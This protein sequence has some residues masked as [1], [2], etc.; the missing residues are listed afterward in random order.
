MNNEQS[1]YYNMKAVVQETGLN[2]M[3][4]RT[5]ERRY[6]LPRPQ[7]SAGGHRQYTQRDIDTFLWL[8]AR[9]AEGLSVRHAA[10]AWHRIEEQG[11]DPLA[12]Q[13]A[14]QGGPVPVLLRTVD[15]SQL[16]ELRDNPIT[17]CLA[18]NKEAAEEV[19]TRAFSCF[20]AGLVCL[21]LLQKGVAQIGV[22]WYDGEISIQQEHFA[23]ALAVRRLDTLVSATARPVRPG[24][25]LV[26]CAP[27]DHHVFSP[28]LLTFLLQRRGWDT[29][30][31]GANVPAQAL[32]ASIAQIR[33]TLVIISAQRLHAAVNL[34]DVAW[35]L[36]EQDVPMG[37]GGRIFNWESSLRQVIPGHFLGESLE[38][39]VQSVETLL[40]GAKGS[41]TPLPV[42]SGVGR[43]RGALQQF[44]ARRALIESHVVGAFIADNHPIDETDAHERGLRTHDHGGAQVGQCAATRTFQTL[45]GRCADQ[46]PP[47]TGNH[48]RLRPGIL[49]CRQNPFGRSGQS[50]HRLAGR[51]AGR[52][53]AEYRLSIW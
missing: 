23:T 33:P 16:D 3:T 53:R 32:Q 46:F 12:V 37:Y 20:P 28:L 30:Y 38:I 4:I 39:A 51:H 52:F 41:P 27:D 2:P 17:A 9:Q 31:L 48:A 14:P 18:F 47:D 11:Q 45:A 13:P 34:L 1:Q 24:R 35:Q 42:D 36:R 50:Y 15:G 5:W 10:E 19:L 7:R 6:G 25:I 40:T 49:S 43:D 26:F 8:I 29:L 44:I 21:E 22:G